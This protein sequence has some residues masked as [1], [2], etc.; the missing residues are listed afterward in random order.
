V[1]I[2]LVGGPGCG[3]VINIKFLN[4]EVNAP[5]YGLY[6]RRDRPW[7]GSGP[8]GAC[9]GE[10]GHRMYDWIGHKKEVENG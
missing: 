5:G 2:E 1:K 8:K 7:L 6:A 10:N 9:Y 3:E 4:F